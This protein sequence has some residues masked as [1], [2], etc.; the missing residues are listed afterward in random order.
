MYG[1]AASTRAF[2]DL[3]TQSGGAVCC[4]SC[5]GF[6]F[7]ADLVQGAAEVLLHRSKA[8]D[9]VLRT[10]L[11]LLGSNHA[12]AECDVACVAR[13][14]ANVQFHDVSI[15]RGVASLVLARSGGKLRVLAEYIHS[16]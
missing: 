12:S 3:G 16:A 8:V 10:N 13:S 11:Y 9:C 4:F 6:E 5:T 14:L 7:G 2:A 15:R 1:S